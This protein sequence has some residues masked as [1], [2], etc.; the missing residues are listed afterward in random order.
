VVRAVN[1]GL[2]CGLIGGGML[3]P[4]GQTFSEQVLHEGPG[5]FGV[6]VFALG[7]GTAAGVVGVSAL[8][9]RLHK[10]RT[11]VLSLFCAG[12]ALIVGV[13]MSTLMLSAM[14]VAIVGIFAGSVYVLGFTLLHENVEDELRRRIFS[15]LYTLV[16]LCVLLAMALAPLLADLLDGVSDR[17]VGGQIDVGIEVSVP[18]VRPTLW[19]AGVIM[20]VAGAL[21]AASVGGLRTGS[22][23]G[24]E[25][26]DRS[27]ER[28]AA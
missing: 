6:F 19:L 22:A 5:G 20:L 25:P 11:F 16:R 9:T 10:A 27:R 17:L 18:G 1:V 8:Q 28:S 4:L 23:V 7:V 2:A 24:V 15:A 14:W 3:I 13:S 26:G 21:S 12:V